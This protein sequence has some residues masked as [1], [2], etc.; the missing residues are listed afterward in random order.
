MGALVRVAVGDLLDPSFRKIFKDGRDESPSEYTRIIKTI[1]VYKKQEKENIFSNLG[2][3]K[4]KAEGK[5]LEYEEPKEGLPKTFIPVAKALAFSVTR[6][7]MDDDL[8]GLIGQVPKDL[9]HSAS[10]TLEQDVANVFNYAFTAADAYYGPDSKSLCAT[11]HPLLHGGTGSNRLA[12]DADLSVTSLQLMS[13]LMR[14]MVNQQNEIMNMALTKL[15]VPVDL[16]FTALE[17][18][19][20]TDRPDTANRATNVLNKR[21]IELVVNPF[22]TDVDAW[23]GQ[24]SLRHRLELHMRTKA[25]FESDNDFGSKSGSFSAFTRYITGWVIHYGIVGTP[26]AA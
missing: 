22:L 12:T 13:T 25:M 16:E 9:G 5:G 26:G 15:I 11:D 2:K 24:N 14:K 23:F 20:S 10:T 7:A 8:T 4:I 3:L 1:S 21:N 17:I 6:E 18:L 19:N